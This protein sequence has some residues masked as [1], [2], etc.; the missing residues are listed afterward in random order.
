MKLHKFV[1]N[2]FV[3]CS[4]E[5]FWIVAPGKGYLYIALGSGNGNLSRD[6]ISLDVRQLQ[7]PVLQLVLGFISAYLSLYA[8][9][10]HP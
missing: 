2:S 5:K 1:I 9:Y 7:I 10:F 8:F 3:N 6:L 4:S